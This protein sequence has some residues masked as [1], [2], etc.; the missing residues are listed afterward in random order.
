ML[1]STTFEQRLNNNWK[2]CKEY[3]DR[4]VKEFN[5]KGWNICMDNKKKS[6]G[7]TDY[8]KQTISISKHFLRGVTCNEKKMRNTVLHE[9]AHIL[10]PGHQHD[11]KWKSVALKIGCDGKVC[12]EMD[13]PDAK[14]IVT[15]KNKCF[16][17]SYF[18]KPKVENKIC[19]KCKTDAILK[20]LK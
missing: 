12:G 11:K 20:I 16:V 2:W 17:N 4:K 15:C 10:T 7:T 5:I 13:L 18:R 19:P 8:S 9:I 6:L 1:N 3:F 14:Y